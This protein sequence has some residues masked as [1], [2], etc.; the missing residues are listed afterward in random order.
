MPVLKYIMFF[1]NGDGYGWSE[2]HWQNNSSSAPNLGTQLG[3]FVAAVATPRAPMLGLDCVLETVRVS[4]PRNGAIASQPVGTNL[5]GNPANASGDESDSLAVLMVN[6]GS[7]SKKVIH[8]RGMWIGVIR[9]G[10]YDPTSAT[11][12]AWDAN[13]QTYKQALVN[14]AYGWLTKDPTNSRKGAGVTYVEGADG[15]VTFTL[16]A[17]G[18][19]DPGGTQTIEVRF[20]GF[21]NRAS[22]LNRQILC[23]WVNATTLISIRQI[24]AGPMT[25][26]GK[27]NYRAVLFNTYSDYAKI[28]AGT[29]KA[30]KPLGR[31]P[32]RSRVQQLY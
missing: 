1:R 11:G 2:S 29:R 3:N 15:R 12:A 26:P 23:Q 25:N 28:T 32:G 31:L 18:I 14:G 13:F 27:F 10:V 24:G 30:G 9:D 4:Y 17:P 6:N 22:I 7:A 21:N 16:P 8:L 19:P 5:T 20:S